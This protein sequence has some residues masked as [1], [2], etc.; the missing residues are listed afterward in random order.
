MLL[1]LFHAD[2][3]KGSNKTNLRGKEFIERTM[4]GDRPPTA[5]GKS[6]W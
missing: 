3:I 1:V 5:A 2:V 4:P 6:G